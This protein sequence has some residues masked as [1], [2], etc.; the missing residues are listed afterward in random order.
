MTSAGD[1]AARGPVSKSHMGGMTARRTSRQ[2][3]LVRKHKQEALL[4]FPIAQYT[5]E[6]LLRLVYTFPVLAVNDENET[7]GASV[8]LSPQGP[9]LVLSSDVPNVELDVLVGHGLHVKTHCARTRTRATGQHP[10]A[11]TFPRAQ[12]EETHLLEWW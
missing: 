7:L 10:H 8:V 2:I 11:T 6:L 1:M 9:N 5:V 12:R 4:H 3:L